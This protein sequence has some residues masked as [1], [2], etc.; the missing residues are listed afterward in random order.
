MLAALVGHATLP[1]KLKLITSAA[2]DIDTH[3]TYMDC[4]NSSPPITDPPGNEQHTITTATT[5]DILAGNT[6]A[7]KR[8]TVQ[9]VSIR[10]THASVSNDVTVVLDAIDGN[11]YELKK[12]TLAPGE[13][14]TW[15]EG[16]GWFQYKAAIPVLNS[17]NKSTADQTLSTTDAY[18]TG[19]NVRLDALGAP[20]IG[21]LYTCTISM[22]K[23]AGTGTPTVIIRV[24]TAGSTADTARITFTLGVGTSVADTAVFKILALFRAVGASAVLSGHIKMVNNLPTTGFGGTTSIKAVQVTSGAF[25]SGVANS[26][27]GISFNGGT[28]FAGTVGLVEV[29]LEKR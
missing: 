9:G 26:I 11:D 28:A 5:T 19:S 16:L 15:S 7:S 22:V 6:S 25:D 4:D 21:L 3:V 29:E 17:T 2:G 14:L 13:E 1:D 12:V 8:R 20:V 10:N 27:M 24:G 23:T 18:L